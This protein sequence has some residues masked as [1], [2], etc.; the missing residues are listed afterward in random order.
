MFGIN[1][2]FSSIYS[3]A[4]AVKAWKNGVIFPRASEKA[5]RG[6]VDK[7]K[8][9]MTV[10]MTEPNLDVILRL[11]D[12]PIVTW[13][14]DN[15]LTIVGYNT[16]S[17]IRFAN[18]CTPV[19]MYVMI[20]GGYFSVNVHGRFYKVA[21]EITFRERDGTWKADKITPWVIPAVNRQRAAQA[22]RA[23]NY[24]EFRDWLIVY[25]QMSAAPEDRLHIEDADALDLLRERKWRELAKYYPGPGFDWKD[26]TKLLNKLRRAIYQENDCIEQKQ[27][28]F[29]D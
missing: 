6:L 15:S 19:P 22:L 24:H 21:D 3:Y 7:R 16:R 10:E 28:A 17:T 1:P 14:K 27:V 25:T 18:K 20:R 23:T 8:R 13:H 26:T 11:Y 29:L 5:P 9:H 4:Y 12:K 2:N